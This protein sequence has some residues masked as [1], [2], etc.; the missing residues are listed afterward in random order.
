MTTTDLFDVL[1]A[2][3]LLHLLVLW[4]VLASVYLFAQRKRE[5]HFK[6]SVKRTGADVD[7]RFDHAQDTLNGLQQ[8]MDELE[9]KVHRVKRRSQS[10][11][12]DIPLAQLQAPLPLSSSSS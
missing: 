10:R 12:V 4:V 9:H 1:P 11:A 8:R 3:V 6:R 2:R 7:L 5:R